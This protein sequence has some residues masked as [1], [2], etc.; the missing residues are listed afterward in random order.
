MF[1]SRIYQKTSGGFHRALIGFLLRMGPVEH[2]NYV[3][4]HI[5]LFG[6]HLNMIS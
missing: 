6:V 3:V 1:N 5:L 2:R 4:K